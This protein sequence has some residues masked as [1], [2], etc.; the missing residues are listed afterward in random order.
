MSK[1]RVLFLC[2]GNSARSQ[3]A[4]GLVNRLLGDVWEA[5]SA[6][7]KP[8]G[9]VHP[10]AVGAM[11]EVDIDITSHRSKSVD[12]FRDVDFDAV[13]TLCGGAAKTC[14]AWLGEGTQAHLGFPDPAAARGSQAEKMAVFRQVRDGIRDRVLG[15]LERLNSEDKSEGGV[16]FG[17]LTL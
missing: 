10:M 9:F 4:E 16:S 5:H 17:K 11:S 14:P 8:S 1:R 3:M 7:T 13:I 15:Y 12:E 6:G 2:T